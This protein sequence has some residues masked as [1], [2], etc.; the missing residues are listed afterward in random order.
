MTFKEKREYLK[1]LKGD[2]S[3]VRRLTPAERRAKREKERE[4][5]SQ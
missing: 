2:S 1:W 5:S 4:H 3:M